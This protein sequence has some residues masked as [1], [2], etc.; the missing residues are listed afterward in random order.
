[1]AG[2]GVG[3][4]RR[5]EM[6]SGGRRLGGERRAWWALKVS[7]CGGGMWRGAWRGWRHGKALAAWRMQLPSGGKRAWRRE[8]R[9]W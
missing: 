3:S 9:V 5:Q 8:R 1:M 7:C 2:R 6:T 4:E